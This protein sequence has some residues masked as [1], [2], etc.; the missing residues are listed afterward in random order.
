[1]LRRFPLRF[2]NLLYLL[3]AVCVLSFQSWWLHDGYSL[4]RQAFLDEIST[5]VKQSFTMMV[6]QS[7]APSI[8]INGADTSEIELA[9]F[10]QSAELGVVD[11][12]VLKA[13][14]SE[15]QGGASSISFNI[16][17]PSKELRLYPDSQ[18]YFMLRRTVTALRDSGSL[19][20]FH[21]VGSEQ[22]SFPLGFRH[23]GSNSTGWID[24]ESSKLG[25]IDVEIPGLHMIILKD[26]L[27][28]ILFSLLYLCLFVWTIL[29]LLRTVNE[30]RRLSES[31]ANFT[32]NMTHELKIPIS[33]LFLA[34]EALTRF[35]DIDDPQK[36]RRHIATIRHG[37]QQLSTLVDRILNSARLQQRQVR[38][39]RNVTGLKP[40]LERVL[41]DM[42]PLIEE[43]EVTVQLGEI[44]CTASIYADPD[45]LRYVFFNLIDNAIKYTP[46]IPVIA[47]SLDV[48]GNEHVIEV[49]DNGIGI[50]APYHDRVFEPYFR[51]PQQDLHDV[52]GYGLGLNI[53]QQIVVLH[54]GSVS[55]MRS[56][57]S[58]T[59]IQ[60]RLPRHDA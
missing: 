33:G 37:L 43:R 3:T 59:T 2:R 48:D 5:Q 16:S 23:T 19:I 27:P 7:L 20:V 9:K 40:L 39:Q 34:T 4:R 28:A 55:V 29:A 49:R 11:S 30:N 24:A 35:N 57:P 54:E 45:Q 32:Q 25:S 60:I 58:G 41:K 56:G 53:V 47:I 15:I 31:K 44:A 13:A 18:M 46:G 8:S 51:V 1:M 50:A 14:R 26:M 17:T 38:L 42:T 6:L 52:K 36:A 21:R 10:M 22:S 12:Q